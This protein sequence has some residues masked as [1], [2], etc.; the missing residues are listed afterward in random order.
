MDIVSLVVQDMVQDVRYVILM[1]V[2]LVQ[3]DLRKIRIIWIVL[4][5]L[6]IVISLQLHILIKFEARLVEMFIIV[7]IALQDM[8]G[9]TKTGNA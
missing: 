3:E 9:Q 1:F 8:P 7:E 5:I 4:L 2:L 6:Q